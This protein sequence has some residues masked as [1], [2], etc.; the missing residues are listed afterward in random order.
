MNIYTT[1]TITQ[2]GIESVIAM[3][4]PVLDDNRI[5][6]APVPAQ[7]MDMTG[8]PSSIIKGLRIGDKVTINFES[9]RDAMGRQQPPSVA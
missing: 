6:R 3:T 5:D 8:I 7:I 1:L 2:I 4:D 9:N